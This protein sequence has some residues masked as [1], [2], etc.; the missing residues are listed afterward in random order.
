MINKKQNSWSIAVF[1]AR[2]NV[3]TLE[4]TITA[5]LDASGSMTTVDVLVNGNRNLA[6]GIVR[7]LNASI[8]SS[9][10]RSA[11]LRVWFIQLGDKAHAWNQYLQV[12]WPKSE[13]TFFIDGYVRVDSNA[14]RLLDDALLNS[15]EYLAATGI[16]SIGWSAKSLRDEML[17]NGGIHG[18]LF[19]LKKSTM[20][21]LRELNFKLPL[22]LY[23]TDST[24]GA[25]L[26]FGLDPSRYSW[27]PKTR[28]LVHSDVTWATDKKVPWRFTDI[29]GQLKR[30]LRQGQ[31]IL[32]NL[33]VRDHLEI[34]KL[35]P[36][37]LPDTATELVLRWTESHPDEF[38]KIFLQQPLLIF[39]A[40]KRLRQPKTWLDI[41]TSPE[42]L[43]TAILQNQK[44][45]SSQISN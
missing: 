43:L 18:N 25:A 17:K 33:A 16:P 4:K 21:A 9:K 6:H 22:G 8:N 5:A 13:L 19:A 45:C 7:L 15:P 30:I 32:E 35:R 23:R 41:D 14:F 28:I 11:N 29:S 20:E 34:R 40:M 44:L 1:A 31:G 24:L 39:L 38:R 3:H 27:S 2:E 10:T 42:L 26:S 37:Q 36:E 12:I